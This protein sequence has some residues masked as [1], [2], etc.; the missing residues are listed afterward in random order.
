M[1]L[2]VHTPVVRLFS[3][4]YGPWEPRGTIE[5]IARVAQAAERLGY[6]YLTCSE[7]VA[8][9]ADSLE[10]RG[11]CYWDPLA[12]FGYLAARTSRIRFVT[13]VLVVPY[14]HP[15][16]I[17]KRYGTLD[18]ICDGRLTLGLGVGYL[19]PEFDV[20]GIPFEDRNDRS[21]DA[22]RALRAAFGRRQPA[23][24]GPFY[25]FDDMV[26]DPC[27]VQTD[28]PLWIGGQSRRSLRRAV[29]L[30]DG[31][32]PFGL[33]PREV[34]TWLAQAQSTDA[35][36][37]R[38]QPLD[39]A[40]GATVDPLAEPEAAAAVADELRDAGVTMLTLRV[41]ARSV[42]HHIEQLEAMTNIVASLQEF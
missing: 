41:V 10:G 13:L 9:P 35:W 24:R 37:A 29:E 28:V 25:Q 33:T 6:E 4:R 20:L 32:C 16:E 11:P 39:I 17:A 8:I 23:Y 18:R 21:D 1:R 2:G 22:I 3:G 27:G 5:D 30:G 15:L 19:K 14:H 40:V 7:H 38:D 31:W 12:T 36:Q 26:V 34:A 42:A